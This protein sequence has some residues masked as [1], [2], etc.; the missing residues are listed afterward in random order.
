MQSKKVH[1]V[2]FRKSHSLLE[3]KIVVLINKLQTGKD[4]EK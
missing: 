4:C 2:P 3:E 1:T